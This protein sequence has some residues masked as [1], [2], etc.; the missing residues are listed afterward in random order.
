MNLN[1]LSQRAKEGYLF[2]DHSQTQGLSDEMVAAVGLPA[3]AGKGV[4]EAPTY[5]CSHCNGV[6]IM[7]PDR[8]RDRAYCTGCDH[9]ICDNCGVIRAQTRKCKTFKQLVDE[10]LA[11]TETRQVDSSIVLPV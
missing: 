1:Q 9:L 4:F 5:T 6:V 7:N 8:K 11:S 2:I 3:G 10:V